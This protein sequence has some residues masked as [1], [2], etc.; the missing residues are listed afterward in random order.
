[1]SDEKSATNHPLGVGCAAVALGVF[2]VFI[3]TFAARF[4]W[5]VAE[6]VLA[7]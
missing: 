2:A 5:G 4:G 3:L 1:M 7:R 6:R